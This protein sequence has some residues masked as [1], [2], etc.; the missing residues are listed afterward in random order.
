MGVALTT[1]VAG[2]KIA[3]PSHT[4]VPSLIGGLE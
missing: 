4:Q 3:V 2:G 1:P